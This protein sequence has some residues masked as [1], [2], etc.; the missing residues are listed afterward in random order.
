MDD[1]EIIGLY[2]ARDE[3][4][5]V[6]TQ[7]KYGT[8]CM[9]I[10]Q[11][12]LN[13]QQDSEECVSDTWMRTWNAIPPGAPE[14]LRPFVGKI[15]RNLA[16]NRLRS[17]AAQR[18]GGGNVVMALEELRDCVPDGSTPE[19][20]LE[21][22]LI[23]DAVNSFLG[24]LPKE[25]RVAFVLRYWYLYSLPEISEKM[26]IRESK[27]KSMLFRLRKELKAHLEQEGIYET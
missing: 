1:Q 11:R 21:E 2:F 14:H 20:A 3:Q 6:A 5:I 19:D 23:S 4:A 18:R 10:A 9:S 24:G 16:L 15:T 12:I 7:M 25:K 13:Q 27:L 8:Y 17:E 22:K 26:G